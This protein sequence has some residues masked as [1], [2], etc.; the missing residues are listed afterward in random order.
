MY[1]T[2]LLP[3]EG[4]GQDVVSETEEGVLLDTVPSSGSSS[5]APLSGSIVRADGLDIGL[6]QAG[7]ATGA[8]F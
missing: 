2:H 4:P 6:E 1:S 5:R 7:F 3:D 8:P